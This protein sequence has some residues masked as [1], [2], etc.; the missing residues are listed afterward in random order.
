MQ[1]HALLSCLQGCCTFLGCL[2]TFLFASNILLS[3]DADDNFLLSKQSFDLTDADLM[4]L[5]RGAHG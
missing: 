1:K 4:D 3:Q 5:Q 2:V